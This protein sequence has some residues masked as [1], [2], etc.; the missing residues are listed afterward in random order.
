V[1]APAVV[2][3]DGTVEPAGPDPSR[4][5]LLVEYPGGAFREFTA[6]W[7]LE[8]R[9]AVAPSDGKPRSEPKIALMFAGNPDAGGIQVRQEGMA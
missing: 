4:V 7:P 9:F 2:H 3:G 6:A 5:V 8:W 1:T